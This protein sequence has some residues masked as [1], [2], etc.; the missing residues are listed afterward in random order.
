MLPQGRNIFGG[1]KGDLDVGMGPCIDGYVKSG[2]NAHEALPSDMQREEL[3]MR[4]LPQ[5]QWIANQ[6]HR[7]LPSHVDIDDLV[8]AGVV[9]LMK[10]Y[11]KYNPAQHVKFGTYAHH[12]IRGAILD[13]LRTTDW[14][15]RGIRRTGRAVEQS[16]ATL[17]S[18]LGRAP[19]ES[20]VASEMRMS[21]G[22]YQ[23]LLGRLA[24]LE[25]GSLNEK[26]D[27]DGEEELAYIP[28]P[29]SDDPLFQCAATEMKR[30]IAAVIEQLPE[31]E[32]TVVTLRYYEE[33]CMQ[34]IAAVLGV[35][36]SRVTQLH[37]AAVLHMRAHLS[38]LGNMAH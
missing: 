21:L 24:G 16:I 18:R 29:Y 7:R 17:A 32:R 10:A 25:I 1:A 23:E 27:R 11:E 20:E 38:E 9:G 8:G 36:P 22:E 15:S 35:H 5:V 26:R 13:S 34:D 31:R 14:A 37:T 30:R 12:R 3:V 28:A 33:L 2:G 6:I 4:H 19:S